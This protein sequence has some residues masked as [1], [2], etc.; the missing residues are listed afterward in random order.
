MS[1][2]N[3]TKAA[4]FTHAPNTTQSIMLTVLLA[5][6]P[7][8]LFDAWLFGWPAIFMFILT[9]GFCLLLEAGCLILQNKPL[10]PSLTDGSVVLTGWLLAMSLPP[11]APWWISLLGAIFAVVLAK[12]LFG[13]IGQNVFNPAMVGR[14]AL[15]VSFPLQMT[16]WVKPS[17]AP[18]FVESL[19]ITFG[20]AS[21]DGISAASALGYVKTELSRGVPVSE[22]V[23]HLPALSDMVLG[24]HPGSFGETSAILILL[25][26]LFLMARKVISW[27]VPVSVIGTIVVLSGLASL[28]D[29]ARFAGPEFHLFAGATFL[30]AF[31]IATDY[32]TSPVSKQGQLVYGAGVGFFTWLIRTFAGYPEGM[33]F[34]VLLMNTLTPIIDHHI[35]PRAFG[36]TRKGEPLPVKGE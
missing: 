32:V 10:T 19:G 26:G 9:V 16:A 5:L 27:H 20:H 30:G 33:A 2:L 18:G 24:I 13:G 21:L 7:A 25:G 31:F 12:Q 11:Y 8:T 14:V 29:P 4:P 6:A 3:I 28:A 17:S 34:A 22:S 1:V 15:L 36:R 23:H 35:R